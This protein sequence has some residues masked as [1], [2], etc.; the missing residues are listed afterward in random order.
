MAGSSN[1][2]VS[3]IRFPSANPEHDLEARNVDNFA[4]GMFDPIQPPREKDL[5][6]P[7]DLGIPFPKWHRFMACLNAKIWDVCAEVFLRNGVRLT[8]KIDLTAENINTI[9]LYRFMIIFHRLPKDAIAHDLMTSN[10]F[11]FRPLMVPDIRHST[12]VRPPHLHS[13]VHGSQCYYAAGDLER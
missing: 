1:M 5:K 12:F 9:E 8:K 4:P 7:G 11:W 3:R 2:Q 6:L 13:H 10:E